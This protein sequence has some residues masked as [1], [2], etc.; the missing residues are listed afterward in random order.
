MYN[1][2][3][4]EA[5]YKAYPD[6]KMIAV[7]RNPVARTFSA[8]K[9]CRTTG[10]EP[11][12]DFDDAIF[13]NDKS[14]FKGNKKLERNCDYVFRSNYLQH[15]KKMYSIFPPENIRIYLLEEIANNSTR[16]LNEM[17]SLLNLP[18][19]NFDIT[20]HH[21]EGAFTK[22][23]FVAKIGSPGKF[24]AFK[25]LF[26]VEQRMKMKAFLK[27]INS[28]EG[29]PEQ[30]VLSEDTRKYLVELF[31]DNVQALDK[32]VDLPIKKY[33]PEFFTTA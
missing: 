14:R 7:L 28:G 10:V 2:E 13:I 30:R 16:P 25:N 11:Y 32:V 29:K 18:A 1:P 27:K 20:K 33:W 4:M 19:F 24:K 23:D 3:L 5:I 9:Y 15:I 21:N 6:C 26:S 8:F 17:V 31:K 12:K 22:S